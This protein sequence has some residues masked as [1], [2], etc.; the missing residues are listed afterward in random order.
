MD[1]K[2]FVGRDGGSERVQEVGEGGEGAGTEFAAL[3]SLC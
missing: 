1:L 2:T 3:I